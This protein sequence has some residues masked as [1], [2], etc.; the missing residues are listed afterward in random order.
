MN[1][2]SLKTAVLVLT[3]LLIPQAGMVAVAAPA[4]GG[5]HIGEPHVEPEVFSP[6][7]FRFD[8]AVY[9]LVVFLLLLALLTKFAWGPVMTALDEREAAIRKNIED[10]EVARVRAEQLLAERAKKLDAVQDEVREI[11]AEAR[12]DAEH[13]KSEIMAA[14]QKESEATKNR[15]LEEVNRAR[16]HAL[17]ELFGTLTTQVGVATEHVL[18]RALNDDDRSRLIEESLAQLNTRA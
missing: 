1:L 12:R 4:G 18:G 2:L 15:A 8:L 13:T 3:L 14:A 6:R 11:L 9:S 5:A 7:D 10:A 17:N 16:D